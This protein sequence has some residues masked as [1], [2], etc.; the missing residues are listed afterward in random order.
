M[1]VVKFNIFAYS[2]QNGKNYI[3]YIIAKKGNKKYKNMTKKLINLFLV[4]VGQIKGEICIDNK[5]Y[6]NIK[7]IMSS[8]PV[9]ILEYD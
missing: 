9:L 5:T 3:G 7:N 1:Y 4:Q 8:Y 2:T 6:E